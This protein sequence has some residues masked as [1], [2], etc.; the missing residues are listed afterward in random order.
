MKRAFLL[1]FIGVCTLITCPITNAQPIEIST[2][3]DTIAMIGDHIELKLSLTSPT[4]IPVI[5][6]VIPDT[7]SPS[8][9]FIPSHKG[10]DSISNGKK[11]IT[12]TKTYL[13]TI[14]NAGKYTIP[15]LEFI[16][17]TKNQ[18]F[19]L[20]TPISITIEAPAVDTTSSIKEIKEIMN[21]PYT[22]KELAPFIFGGLGGILLLAFIIYAIYRYIN[23]K[24][25]V[26]LPKKPQIPADILA[27]QQMEELKHKKLW[28]QNFTKE[29]YTELTEILRTYIQDYLHVQAIEITSDELLAIY[30]KCVFGDNETYALLQS[31]LPLSDSVKFA[32]NIPLPNENDLCFSQALSFIELTRQKVETLKASTNLENE[33]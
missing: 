7:L 11:G 19:Y 16:A 25:I 18:S 28:Q 33:K 3:C 15:A 1:F 26:I 14:F 31:I 17:P 5:F 8:I 27:L 12:Y 10:Y 6:P 23:K 2:Q 32:K 24:P 9:E 20:S 21:V 29:Y 30:E 4:S 22:F 13:F